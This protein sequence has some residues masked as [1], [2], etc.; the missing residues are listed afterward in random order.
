MELERE[1]EPLFLL[2][3]GEGSG[4]GFTTYSFL[5]RPGEGPGSD[6]RSNILERTCYK[7]YNC[8]YDIQA[9]D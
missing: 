4:L 7:I 9:D 5:F 3:T 1:S 6:L 2:K 8:L